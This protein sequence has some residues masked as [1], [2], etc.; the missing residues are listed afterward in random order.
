M[1]VN[2]EILTNA[3]SFV[4]LHPKFGPVL[5]KRDLHEDVLIEDIIVKFLGFKDDNVV[6]EIRFDYNIINPDVPPKEDLAARVIY[7]PSNGLFKLT[8]FKAY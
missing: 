8:A 1:K 4:R 6:I 2:S 7:N 5:S 3:I